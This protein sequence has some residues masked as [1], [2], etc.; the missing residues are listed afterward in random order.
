M[1]FK[2]KKTSNKPLSCTCGLNV[3]PFPFLFPFSFFLSFFL[4]LF[5]SFFFCLFVQRVC[6]PVVDDFVPQFPKHQRDAALLHLRHRVWIE[7]DS[8]C[9]L[10]GPAHAVIR[11]M[12]ACI[13]ERQHRSLFVGRRVY[14][15][16]LACRLEDSAAQYM[17]A[18]N[19]NKKEEK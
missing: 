2:K 3:L 4:F 16:I 7:T 1:D 12:H 13:G 14:M 10:V 6:G 5:F 19:G 18:R 17:S 15:F 9:R 8:Q 11:C